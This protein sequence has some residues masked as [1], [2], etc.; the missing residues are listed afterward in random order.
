MPTIA[1]PESRVT[2]TSLRSVLVGAAAALLCAAA[3]T[4]ISLAQPRPDAPPSLQCPTADPQCTYMER[5]LGLDGYVYQSLM[6]SGGA[7]WS[8]QFWVRDAQGRVLL[9]TAALRGSAYL[10]VQRADGT[11]LDA[12]P[13]VRVVNYHYAPNDPAFAPSGLDSTVYRYDS[14]SDSLIPDA[15]SLQPIATPET[16]RQMLN[17]DGWTLVFPAD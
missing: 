15:P 17:T 5:R 9:A 6:L 12:A 2:A 8:A 10:A 13:A 3:T 11:R 1:F 4:A 16:I 14:R 7:D